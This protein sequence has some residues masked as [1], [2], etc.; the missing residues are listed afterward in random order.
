V[1]FPDYSDLDYC[2]ISAMCAILVFGFY[3]G[4]WYY[5]R[6]ARAR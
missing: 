4:R 6:K 2:L 3:G 5:R 1:G